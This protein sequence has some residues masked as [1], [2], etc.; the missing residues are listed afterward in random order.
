M[1][2]YLRKNA[3]VT[4]SSSG[5]GLETCLT[6]AENSFTTYATMR[7]LDKAPTVLEFAEKKEF[8]NKCSSAGCN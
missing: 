5:I 2:G 4:G 1:D 6:L 8:A 7:N 3:I